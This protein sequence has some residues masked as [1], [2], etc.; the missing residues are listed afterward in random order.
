MKPRSARR[1]S[2]TS[3]ISL[4]PSLDSV[5]TSTTDQENRWS[6]LS[7]TTAQRTKHVDFAESMSMATVGERV[8]VGA[9]GARTETQADRAGMVVHRVFSTEG[10]SPFDQVDWELRTAEIKD[11]RGRV[12]FQ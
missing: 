8:S 10:V 1:T 4:E 2:G 7:V 9:G 3:E 11:E 12:I 6:W 5:K